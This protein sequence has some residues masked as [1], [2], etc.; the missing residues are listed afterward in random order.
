MKPTTLANRYARAVVRVALRQGESP[1][2]YGELKNF[3]KQFSEIPLLCHALTN[4]GIPLRKKEQVLGEIVTVPV[5]RRVILYLIRKN[6]L[7]LLGDIVQRAQQL[8]DEE[9]GVA[10]ATVRTAFALSPEQKENLAGSLRDFFQKPVLIEE[11]I[12]PDLLAGMR[13]RVGDTILDNSLK[14]ELEALERQL[15]A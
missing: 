6:Q 5:L 12:E 7:A 3:E 8:L 14:G 10:R 11:T 1:S 9:E 13:I 15:L 4:P 2:W